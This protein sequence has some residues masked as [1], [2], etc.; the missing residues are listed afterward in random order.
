MEKGRKY[1]MLDNI[2]N[3]PRMQRL[4]ATWGIVKY[5]WELANEDHDLM[6]PTVR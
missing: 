1:Q 6:K 4:K 5:S 3:K 2:V